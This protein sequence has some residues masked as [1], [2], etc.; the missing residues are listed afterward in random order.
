MPGLVGAVSITGEA[1]NPS[2]L[3]AMRDAIRHR[4]W[5]KVDDYVH[6][7]GTVAISRVGLGIVN[8]SKQPY[9]AGNGRVKV[10]LHGE[11]YNDEIGHSNPLAFIY[12]LYEKAGAEFAASLHGSFVV[13]I[14]DE[15]QDVVL[16]ANDRIAA[17]PL[18]CF[19]DGRAVYFGPE[20]KSLLPVPSLARELN[21]AALADFLASGHFTAEHTLI[22]GLKTMDSATVLRITSGGMTQ[23]RYW[24]FENE[25]QERDRGP[26]YYQT[27][28][29]ELLR[30]A[31]HRRLR[32]DHTYGILLSGGYDSRAILGC[33]LEERAGEKPNTLSWGREEDIPDSDCL[34]AKR[35][36][37]EI[38]AQHKFYHL[39]ARD[40][41]DRFQEF[42]FLGEGL[43]DFPECYDVFHRIKQEQHIDIVLRG[44]ECFG[45]SKWLKVH[46]ERTMFIALGLKSLENTT[47]YQRILKPSYYRA[48]CEF[49]AETTRYRSSRC[50]ARN[51]HNRKDF[52][53]LDVRLKNYLNPLN[54]VKNFYLES[55]T[56]F[57]DYDLLDFV[58]ALPVR[59]KL[60]KRF[61]RSTVVNMFPELYAEMAQQHNM[62]DWA[63][64]LR[65]SP[66]LERFVYREL[67]ES[68]SVLSEFMNI[69]GLKSEL[70][71]FF[72][73]GPHLQALGKRAR[74][75]ALKVL[76]WSPTAYRLAH[77]CFYTIQKHRG[78][79]RDILLP[80]QWVIRLL[81]LKAWGDMFLTYPVARAPEG[82]DERSHLDVP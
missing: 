65:D 18:F 12:R 22:Q 48:F 24:T 19:S 72:S 29:A 50:S 57:L 66:E 27:R 38:G 74:G 33:Y 30:N 61:Y 8:R 82:R 79:V 28:L 36:A 78:K 49:D 68:Q 16:V 47:V 51:L 21:L 9:S 11:L 77:K 81:I 32:S 3:P 35:L 43:T 37:K 15:D 2:L 14:V 62:I 17:K 6:A 52:F 34:I 23:H 41:I 80:E 4:D 26:G 46:D 54:Y 25:R 7:R 42:V 20:M 73:T 71:T 56:P 58:G 31:V 67:L 40:V 69:D 13:V 76:G 70:D 64:S 39:T 5:Y 63:T 59:Y 55:F 75:D 45:F 1:I 53:Y 44:D 10:F 60:G